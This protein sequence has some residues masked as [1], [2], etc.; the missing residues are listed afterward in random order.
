MPTFHA[1]I[2]EQLRQPEFAVEYLRAAI[3]E[4]KVDGDEAFFRR[5]I[6]T[7]IEAS[8]AVA[9]EAAPER[10]DV[11]AEPGPAPYGPPTGPLTESEIRAELQRHGFRI[12]RDS[13]GGVALVRI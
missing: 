11:I 12:E 6:E 7:M 13:A 5:C 10:E 9:P 1:L 4:F 3:E 2:L 8:E